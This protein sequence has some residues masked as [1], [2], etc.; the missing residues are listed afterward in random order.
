MKEDV[1]YKVLDDST[2]N[3]LFNKYNGVDI[4]RLSI[5]VPNG[6]SIDHIVEVNLRKFKVVTFPKVRYIT[7]INEP[8]LVFTSRTSTV[9]ELH[10]R[11]C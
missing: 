9:L 4:P 2:W 10:T 7:G 3:Y 11:I 1:H 5:A 6:D 8:S